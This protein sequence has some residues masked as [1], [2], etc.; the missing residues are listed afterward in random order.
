VRGRIGILG[1]TFDPPHIGHLVV[2]QD[3]LERLDLDRLIVVPAGQPPHR[4]AVLDAETRLALVRLAFE[5]DDRIQVSD[6][7]VGREGPSWTVDTLEWVHR[8][9]APQALYLIVGADQLQSFRDW[10]APER[11][12]KLARLAVMTRPGEELKGTDVPHEVIEVT[13]VDLSSTRIRQRLEEGRSIRYTVPERVR[14]VVE[15]A[16]SAR[17]T[18][19]RA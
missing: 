10:R 1:G 3:V 11:I 4:E 5:G 6:I 2:A 18:Q 19:S 12:L 13:R 17:R 7:E 9:L 8:E 15:Q 16:W 14:P